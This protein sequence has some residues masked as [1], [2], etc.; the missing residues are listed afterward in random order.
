MLLLSCLPNLQQASF[1]FP[2]NSGLCRE[3]NFGKQY[4]ST[5]NPIFF[6]RIRRRIDIYWIPFMGQG[7]CQVIY[8]YFHLILRIAL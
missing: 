7:L 2:A 6:L 4:K 5:T 1:K 3:G 8:T